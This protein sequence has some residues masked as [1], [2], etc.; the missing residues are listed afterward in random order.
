MPD[1]LQRITE[2]EAETAAFKKQAAERA[3][4]NEGRISVKAERWQP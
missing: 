2:L 4:M 1:L 3:Q